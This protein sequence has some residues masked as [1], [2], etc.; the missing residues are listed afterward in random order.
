MDK[1]QLRKDIKLR[2]QGMTDKDEQSNKIANLLLACDL[3]CKSICIYNS[4]PSEVNTKRLIEEFS[5][6]KEVYLPV[7]EGDDILLVKVDK[8]TRYE[9]AKWGISEPVG[10]RLKPEDVNPEITITPLLGADVNLNRLGKGKGF[11]DRYFQ[12][13]NTYKI[14]LAFYEQLEENIPCDEWDKKLDMLVLPDRIIK[15]Q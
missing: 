14:G 8:D 7:V 6:T 4:L 5:K 12:K 10:K 9:E 13:V 11:Y 2:L 15:R 3:P 1:Q